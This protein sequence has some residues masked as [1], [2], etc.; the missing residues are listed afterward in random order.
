[1]SIRDQLLEVQ[2]KKLPERERELFTSLTRILPHYARAM[3]TVLE[4]LDSLL[5]RRVL[6][7]VQQALGEDKAPTVQDMDELASWS[8]MTFNNWKRRPRS[9]AARD[10]T[11]EQAFWELHRLV[12]RMNTLLGAL[13]IKPELL[14]A[15]QEGGTAEES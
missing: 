13:G 4:L 14:P 9:R 6:D 5:H 2:K 15:T 3:E 12:M 10:Q 1:M 7:G 8:P 11:D